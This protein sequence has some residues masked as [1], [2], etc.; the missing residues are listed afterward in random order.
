MSARSQA[1]PRRWKLKACPDCGNALT[2]FALCEH[3]RAGDG[4]TGIDFEKLVLV[5][6][7]EDR[8]VAADIEAVAQILEAQYAKEHD[9]LTVDDFKPEAREILAAVFSEVADA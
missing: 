2:A 5:A 4:P 8:A 1:E 6:A 3:Q 7:R 9:G